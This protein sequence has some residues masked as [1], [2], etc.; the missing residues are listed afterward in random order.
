MRCG[1]RLQL[2]V[3]AETKRR[4]FLFERREFSLD[5]SWAVSETLT[6]TIPGLLHFFGGPKPVNKERKAIRLEK[7]KDPEW[8]S[9][10]FQ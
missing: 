7:R 4:T 6:F 10:E 2:K 9:N 1:L 5:S 3:Y 8:K